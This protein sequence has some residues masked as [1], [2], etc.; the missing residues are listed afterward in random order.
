MLLKLEFIFFH[1]RTLCQFCNDIFQIP[2]KIRAKFG[3]SSSYGVIQIICIDYN[4]T[5]PITFANSF[6]FFSAFNNIKCKRFK[7][8]T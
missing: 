6:L 1:K 3:Q 5:F 7:L 4:L 8:K 2:R